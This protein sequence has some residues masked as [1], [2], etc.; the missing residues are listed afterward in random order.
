LAFIQKFDSNDKNFENISSLRISKEIK[1][2]LSNLNHSESEKEVERKKRNL[3]VEIMNY[4]KCRTQSFTIHYHSHL[5]S[6][7][8]LINK[9][10]VKGEIVEYGNTFKKRLYLLQKLVVYKKKHDIM[11]VK[12]K[13]KAFNEL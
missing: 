2:L 11:I 10:T 9:L 1:S 4:G 13:K 7:N 12:S 5:T 3:K 8:E 6:F